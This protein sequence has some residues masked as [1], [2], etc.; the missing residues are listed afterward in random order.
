MLWTRK[1]KPWYVGSTTS[2]NAQI[3][4]HY[5]MATRQNLL[6]DKRRLFV[7]ALRLVTVIAGIYQIFFGEL[8]I[9]IYIMI[10][11]GAI[12]LP[13]LFTRNRIRTVPLELELIFSIMVFIAL[14]VGETLD[15]YQSIPYYDKF[16][17]F[18]L[19]LFI[20]LTA[21][22]LA[23]T[24]HETGGLKMR[25]VPLLI[26]VVLVTMGIG[27]VWEVIEYLYDMLIY[28]H[29]HIFEKLQGST[30]ETPLVD[31][32]NDLIFDMVGGLF[33]ALLALR[34]IESESKNNN[35]RLRRLVHEI[36]SNFTGNR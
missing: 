18:M 17:H 16:V 20:G 8:V 30:T 33:G 26:I 23:Y 4:Y 25:R 29:Y 21:F 7:I 28:P 3:R 10:A 31:T 15:F 6:H 1:L 11:T 24:F 14:V 22:L 19:P 13:G 32:M 35:S 9:G 5:S 12:M 27:A 2:C 36:A 34:Y